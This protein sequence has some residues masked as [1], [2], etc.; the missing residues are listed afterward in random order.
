MP[1]P[2]D[3]RSAP[4][5]K[6]ETRIP[7]PH[8]PDA[9]AKRRRTRRPRSGPS[10][11]LCY[12]DRRSRA[13]EP[14]GVRAGEGSTWSCSSRAQTMTMSAALP[15][16]YR[17]PMRHGRGLAWV[18]LAGSALHVLF[19]SGNHV[20]AYWPMIVA[21][22]TA[23]PYALLCVA[24]SPPRRWTVTRITSPFSRAS[25]ATTGGS[26]MNATRWIYSA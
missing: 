5:T 13:N 24:L 10:F 18:M 26:C 1:P 25:T 4:R 6:A 7:L 8:P 19:L 16:S 14:S 3:S 11:G 2:W 22:D 20:R 15:A 12:H 17:T 23:L 21:A 9:L